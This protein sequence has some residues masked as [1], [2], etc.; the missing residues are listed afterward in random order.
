M[1]EENH[2][3]VMQRVKEVEEVV[4]KLLGSDNVQS[5]LRRHLYKSVMA[6]KVAEYDHFENEEAFVLPL[7]KEHMTVEQQMDCVR[8]LLYE[9]N[10]EH[11]RWIYDF[12]WENLGDGERKLLEGLGSDI[13]VELVG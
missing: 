9:E 4:R 6:L 10:S 2:A 13:G 7:V 12:I 8:K 5:Q 11:P 3:L 1:E